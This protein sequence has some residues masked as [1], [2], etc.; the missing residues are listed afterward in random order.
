MTRKEAIAAIYASELANFGSEL[1]AALLPAVR[2]SSGKA[3]R[4]APQLTASYL[5]GAP[6]L[7]PDFVWP[8]WDA[9][10]YLRGQIER[11]KGLKTVRPKE[12]VAK[13]I[14][15]LKDALK[16]PI[17]PLSFLAQ[18]NLADVAK[19]R[20]AASLPKTGLLSFFFELTRQCSGF[21]PHASGA[22][23]VVY[24]PNTENLLLR[25]PPEIPD[26]EPFP[27]CALAFSEICTLPASFVAADGTPLYRNEAYW[28]LVDAVTDTKKT[29]HQIGGHP[30]QIQGDMAIQCQLASNGI[31]CGSHQGYND[32]GVPALRQGAADWRLLLQI[33][34]DH[35][36]DWMWGDAG[37]LYF[38]IRDQ[39]L[40]AR[41]FDR[42]WMILQCG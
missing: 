35:N 18:I 17:L 3:R 16:D 13:R 5:G 25:E 33:D 1:E 24:T 36:P 27:P 9:T 37:M 19:T 6:A 26:V 21:D 8:T 22:F 42:A 23:R 12:W 7:P 40:A 2:A 10:D 39:D 41:D 29:R 15:E 20:A 38:W 14:S 4:R 34:S 11:R 31:N 30:N 32:P 28:D